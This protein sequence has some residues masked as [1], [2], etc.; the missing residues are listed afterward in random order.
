M[1]Y[2]KIFAVLFLLIIII[3]IPLALINAPSEVMASIGTLCA[4]G[5]IYCGVEFEWI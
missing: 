3:A 1:G 4:V 2:I 5:A